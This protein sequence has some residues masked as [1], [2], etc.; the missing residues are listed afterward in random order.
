LIVMTPLSAAQLMLSI[1][2]YLGGHFFDTQAGGS[3]VL[4]QHFFWIF[5]HPEVYVLIIPGFAF[6]SEIIPVF[7]RKAIFGYPAMVAAVVGIG[8]LSFGVWAHHMFTIGMPPQSNT[9]FALITMAVGIPTGI[10]IFN[11]L[12]TLWGGKIRFAT[13]M[14]FCLAFLFQ[15]LVAGLTGIMLASVPFDWQLSDSYFVVAHFHYVLVG[16]LVMTIFGALY[17]WFPKATGRMLSERLGRWHFWLFVIGFHLTFD[18]MHIP[19]LLG[20][21]RRI[22]TYEPDRGWEVFNRISTLGVVFQAAGIAIFLWNV[23]QALRRGRPAGNDPWDAWTLEWVVTSPPPSYNFAKLPVVRSRRPLWDFKH[24][25]DPDWKSEGS[26]LDSS[27]FEARR[28][29][30]GLTPRGPVGMICLIIAE[31]AIFL[32]FVVAYL[33]Y[34]GKS[35]TGPQPRDVL[36]LPIFLTICLL[37]SSAT[38][39][40]AVSALRRGSV[41]LFRAW[42]VATIALAAIFLAGTGLEWKRLIVEKGLTIRTNLF[43]TT[44]YSLVG[45][46]AFHVT[47]GLVFFLVVL[48]LALGGRVGKEHAPRTHV[49]AM[50]WHFVDA[51]WIVVFTVVYVVGR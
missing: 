15:F 17:Y 16:G 22:Y 7:S 27:D 44:F 40:L 33:F 38:I 50:Y 41:G 37:S 2:R 28:A 21:P 43:G 3:A 26:G 20:M 9:F 23:V 45:L 13:P 4:W 32:I 49:L 8:F 34:L 51:V 24:P 6:V 31:A 11:W 46:H 29:E 1:D 14:L 19:G 5:G 10:K 47:V 35:A 48:G 18:T 39:G 42:W 30:E 25:D 36:D 12:G